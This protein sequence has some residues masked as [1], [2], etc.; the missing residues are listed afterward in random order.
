MHAILWFD[1]LAAY[2]ALL[3]GVLDGAAILSRLQSGQSARECAFFLHHAA[4][5]AQAWCSRCGLLNLYCRCEV[6]L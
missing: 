5:A 6:R 1:L 3:V 4:Q 2:V